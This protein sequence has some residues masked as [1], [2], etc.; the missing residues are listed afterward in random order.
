MVSLK[1]K[2]VDTYEYS[3]YSDSKIHALIPQ[4][5]VIIILDFY[6]SLSLRIRE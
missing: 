6:N 2:I 4:V 1:P 3:Y 5:L